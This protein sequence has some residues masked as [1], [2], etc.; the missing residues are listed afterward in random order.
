MTGY[1]LQVSKLLCSTFLFCFQ[2]CYRTAPTVDSQAPLTGV[3]TIKSTQSVVAASE[4][5]QSYMWK[6]CEDIKFDIAS[7][8]PTSVS[9]GDTV[10]VCLQ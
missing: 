2:V 8:L 10:T 3:K 6:Q 5:A 4:F 9:K 1:K 7:T